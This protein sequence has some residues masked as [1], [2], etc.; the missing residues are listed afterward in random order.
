MRTI[1]SVHVL[2]IGLC[3]TSRNYQWAQWQPILH[4]G[5]SRE[6]LLFN[7]SSTGGWFYP[8]KATKIA[9]RRYF[10]FTKDQWLYMWLFEEIPLAY[11]Q[12][13]L[14]I[15]LVIKHRLTHE[16][17]KSWNVNCLEL[18]LRIS[19]ENLKVDCFLK[20]WYIS[21][22]CENIFRLCSVITK[23]GSLFA[24]LEWKYNITMHKN[25]EF[26]IVPNPLLLQSIFEANYDCFPH[27]ESFLGTHFWKKLRIQNN[28]STLLLF[29]GTWYVY[30]GQCMYIW[31]KWEGLVLWI[32]GRL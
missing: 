29:V 1:L 13:L 8:A 6:Y 16:S 2:G 15:H 32:W 18:K 30:P 28:K 7:S 14:L 21:Y 23:S 10:V 24:L 5:F 31:F 4:K 26:Y 25:I 12:S 20:K 9:S 19:L 17:S 11:S 3:V 27:L 22:L